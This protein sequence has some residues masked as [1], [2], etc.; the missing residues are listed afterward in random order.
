MKNSL[1]LAAALGLA[2]S[3]SALAASPAP[4]RIGSLPILLGLDAVRS[5]L[6]LSPAQASRIDAIRTGFRNNARKIVAA[7]GTT[8][9]SHLAADSKLESLRVKSNSEALAVLSSKQKSRLTE[10][11]HQILGGSTLASPAVQKQL[12]LSPAQVAAIEKIRLANLAYSKKVASDFDDGIIS[13]HERIELL[14]D[15]RLADAEKMLAIL[16]PDQ[17]RAKTAL[18]GRPFKAS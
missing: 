6:N 14:R 10:I 4:D 3:S 2:L 13:H 7:A 11:E 17:R 15:R 1:L 5:E 18:A 9:E 8:K 12:G 16:E